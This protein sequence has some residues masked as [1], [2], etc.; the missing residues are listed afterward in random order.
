MAGILLVSLILA[1]AVGVV[2]LLRGTTT[3]APIEALPRD[4]SLLV[5]LQNPAELWRAVA[6]TAL[7]R[8][9]EEVPAAAIELI[10]PALRSRGITLPAGAEAFLASRQREVLLALVPSD[11][12]TPAGLVLVLDL[13]DTSHGFLRQAQQLLGSEARWTSRSRHGREYITMR[14]QGGN[15]HV[16][17]LKGLGIVTSTGVAMRSVLDV[18]DGRGEPLGS[19]P[20]Y[21]AARDRLGRRAG[22]LAWISGAWIVDRLERVFSE[23][24]ERRALKLLGLEATSGIGLEVDIRGA[25][26]RERLFIAMKG[27]R[28]GLPAE[29]MAGAARQHR[30]SHL[31]PAGFPFYLSVSCSH[32]DAVYRRLPEI[33]ATSTGGNRRELRE[34]L[35]GAEKFMALDLASGLF[36]ALG[37][38]LV[39]GFGRT[40]PWPRGAPD[41]QLL[42]TPAVA[43]IGVANRTTISGFLER[44]DGLARALSAYETAGREQRLITSYNLAVLAPLRPAYW[45]TSGRMMAATSPEMLASAL[46]AGAR[47]ES[48]ADLPGV[49]DLLGRLPDRSHALFMADPAKVADVLGVSGRHEPIA[50]MGAFMGL[51]AVGLSPIAITA[52]MTSSGLVVDSVGSVSPAL[53]IALSLSE[54]ESAKDRAEDAVRSGLDETIPY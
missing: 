32:L 40:S 30:A 15:L 9:D 42:Q 39:I 34:R 25:W 12:N 51:S 45:L 11:A 14:T 38:E 43:S 28:R 47:G 4:T 10:E 5:R 1:C 29:L 19:D 22:V 49:D 23:S 31:V 21:R 13:G 26:F 27:E 35:E 7:A 36:A 41:R 48:W 33:L 8:P 3:A 18:L 6:R 24:S 37:D 16:A 2:V 54:R 50:G 44:L 53:L 46:D 17:G 52:R 20:A